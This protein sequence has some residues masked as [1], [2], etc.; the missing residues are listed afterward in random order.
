MSIDVRVPA[1]TRSAVP[2]QAG[3]PI[4]DVARE[5]GLDP[6]TIVKLASNENPLGMSP[7]AAAALAHVDAVRYPDAGGHHLKA[8][9]AATLDVSPTCLTLGNGSENVLELVAKA[10]LEPGTSAVSSQYAF[11]VWEQAVRAVGA[12]AIVVPALDYGN[13]VDALLAAI[14][15]D[16]A[17]LYLANPN[18]PTGT[19]IGATEMVAFLDAVPS[20]VLV[21]LDEA[22]NEYLP[23]ERRMDSVSFVGR[24]PNVMLT[25]TF[26]K[27]YGLAGLRVGYAVSDPEIAELMNRMRLVFNVSAPAQAAAVAALGDQ[28][29]L[30]R[31]YAT[32][33]AGMQQ[34]TA[35]LDDLAIPYVPS[36]GNFVMIE[37]GDGA[38][39][40]DALL[41]L[42]VIVRPMA[43]YGLPQWLRVSIGL[44]EENL[45]FVTA[46]M[47]AL[48]R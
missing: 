6:A 14:R 4:D 13:D 37:V 40:N 28:D 44:P 3:R 15:P 36:L 42:G 7:L 21:V 16:T 45:R 8:T 32:N 11:V 10:F 48:G 18:N 5:L 17:A 26:S 30:D 25:R 35:V 38:A 43:M 34:L 9:L 29:F 24:F 23:P 2:Y 39:V 41:R 22:Y 27:V 20:R 46:L 33:R 47:S 31:S 19:F 1:K 12:E